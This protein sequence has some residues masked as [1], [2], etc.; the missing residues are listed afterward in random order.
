M[1]HSFKIASA[2]CLMLAFSGSAFASDPYVGASLG[3]FNVGT[4]VSKKGLASG[5]AEYSPHVRAFARLQ[6]NNQNQGDTYNYVDGY[7][8]CCHNLNRKNL[9]VNNFAE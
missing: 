7:D 6:K 5:S 4:G 8:K 1:S 3:A 9:K 2:F